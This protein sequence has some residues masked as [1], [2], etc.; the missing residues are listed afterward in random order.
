VLPISDPVSVV[1]K[2]AVRSDRSEGSPSPTFRHH[3]RLRPVAARAAR[4]EGHYSSCLPILPASSDLSPAVGHIRAV[5]DGEE[6]ADSSI[7]QPGRVGYLAA[8]TSNPRV[9]LKERLAPLR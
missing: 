8:K 6:T 3:A 9:N 2:P 7:G 4:R 5:R 1:T